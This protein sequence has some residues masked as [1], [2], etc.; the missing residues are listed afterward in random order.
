MKQFN[1]DI[2]IWFAEIMIGWEG[3][4]YG[5]SWNFPD[6]YISKK[7]TKNTFLYSIWGFYYLCGFSLLLKGFWV[8]WKLTCS[9]S[10][11]TI[12]NTVYLV[13]YNS[14]YYIPHSIS[15]MYLVCRHINIPVVCCI[16]VAQNQ[17]FRKINNFKISQVH[18]K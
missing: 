17:Y 6:S 10:I 5:R 16:H 1:F 15:N 18:F 2:V 8:E 3:K 13:L 4:K 9:L 11:S 12:P 7:C 14:K